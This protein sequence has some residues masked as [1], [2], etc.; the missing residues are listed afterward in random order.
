MARFAGFGQEPVEGPNPICSTQASQLY[1]AI[2]CAQSPETHLNGSQDDARSDRP[3]AG[4]EERDG[5]LDGRLPPFLRLDARQLV[6]LALVVPT[7][8]TTRGIPAYSRF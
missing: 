7:S 3:Y 1:A 6:L 2:D 5:D 4:D 8:V